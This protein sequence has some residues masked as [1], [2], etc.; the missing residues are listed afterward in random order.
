MFS[1][2]MQQNIYSCRLGVITVWYCVHAYGRIVLVLCRFLNFM[3][4]P[5]IRG[6]HIQNQPHIHI[7]FISVSE[8][9]E[10]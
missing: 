4:G 9:Y 1:Y 3:K 5:Y 7:S 6:S 8:Q 2:H 10:N